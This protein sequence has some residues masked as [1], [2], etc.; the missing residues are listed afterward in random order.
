MVAIIAPLGWAILPFAIAILLAISAAVLHAT[1]RLLN[2]TNEH[3]VPQK[4]VGGSGDGAPPAVPADDRINRGAGFVP[5]IASATKRGA[6]P[7]DCLLVERLAPC[8]SGAA[9]GRRS[10]GRHE[11]G[12]AV[13]AI[14]SRADRGRSNAAT[15]GRP[16]PAAGIRLYGS[17]RRRYRSW[18]GGAVR[19]RVPEW[20]ERRCLRGLTVPAA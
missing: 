12:S 1:L 7:S 19:S 5:A 16:G 18:R 14:V 3:P 4:C 17:W 2:E 13:D 15:Q 11:P 20:R 6:G 8:R 10:G 9:V